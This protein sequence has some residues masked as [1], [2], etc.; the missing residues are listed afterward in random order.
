MDRDGLQVGFGEV[1]I[2]PPT[3]LYMCGGLQPR[4]NVGTDDPLMAKA[5]VA[6]AGGK[7]IAI[8]GVDLIGLPR[9]FVDRAIQQAVASTGLEAEA[10]M[11]ACSHTHSGPYTQEG[12]YSFGVTNAEY[13]DTLPGAIASSIEA[14]W[15]ALRPARMHIGRSLVY[16][17]L[18]HR[19]VVTKDGKAVNTW[20]SDQL[21]DLERC[22]QIVGTAGPI[23]PELWVLRFDGA[24]GKP[25]GA[26][27]N[28]SLHVNTHFGT[29]WS[30][31]Y[32]GVMAAN[33]RH[34]YG[35]HF[36][37]VFTP[38]ACA[39]INTTMGGIPQWREAA[40]YI[41]QQALRAAKTARPVSEPVAVG[42]VR[43]DLPVPRRDP[44]T[45][46][47]EAIARLDWGGG[48]SWP[49]VFEPM[50]EHIGSLPER[51]VVP[52]NAVRLGPFGL[53]SN[54]GELFVEHGLTI[55][56]RSPFPHTAVAELTND[57]ILYQPTREAFEQQGYETLVGANRVSMEGI[58]MIVNT[59]VELLNALWAA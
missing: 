9:Q 5:L 30:A 40:E 35:A 18:H 36:S 24:D 27:V 59:A 34:V 33:F 17:L 37:T 14:A 6:R 12:L 31:D 54:P 45:Q 13:L 56:R 44:A 21:N 49:E 38:G 39:N 52:I 7:A 15:R 43:R 2:T 32:P 50:L 58:E 25:F 53:A 4:T 20:M 51:L 19:R 16:H 8:V 46:P 57:I 22:P 41:A 10:I 47:P 29:A 3:G 26:L 28:F 11:V 42:G 1:E 48:R 55:K 23:D